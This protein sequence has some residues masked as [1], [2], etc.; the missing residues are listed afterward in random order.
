MTR[1]SPEAPASEPGPR[2]PSRRATRLL[3]APLRLIL[4][5]LHKILQVRRLL[6]EVRPDVL[7]VNV[8]GYEPV[9]YAA[10]LAGVPSVGMYCTSPV[11]Q[12]DWVRRWLVRHTGKAYTLVASKS[13]ATADSWSDYACFACPTVVWNGIDVARFAAAGAGRVRQTGPLRLLS[14]GRLSQMK[15]YDILIRAVS[16]LPAGAVVLRIAG[17]GELRASLEALI[18][19]LG[20]ADRVIL[21]GHCDAIEVLY[22]ESDVFVIAS[23]MLESFCSAVAEAL[24]AGMPVVASRFGPFEELLADG[25]GI[26]CEPGNA[27]ELAEAIRRLLEMGP[28]ER[29]TRGRQN[30]AFA[31]EHLTNERMIVQTEAVYEAAVSAYRG[32]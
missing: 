5:N 19:E 30:Q 24:A 9:G 12:E 18:E 2:R 20:V 11:A 22:G 25:R 7:H 1:H 8:D 26:L 13:R 10:R 23:T 29:E 21:L 17:E 32:G 28:E 31:R 15:R 4:G 3:P 6:L 27:E 16:L 14:V